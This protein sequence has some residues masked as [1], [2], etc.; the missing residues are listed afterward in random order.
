[1]IVAK[2]TN[3]GQKSSPVIQTRATR[4]HQPQNADAGVAS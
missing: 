3:F 4:A 2:N 1:M